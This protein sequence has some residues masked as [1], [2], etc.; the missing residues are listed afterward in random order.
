MDSSAAPRWGNH[1]ISSDGPIVEECIRTAGQERRVT[2]YD[3]GGEVSRREAGSIP[4]RRAER[5]F[6]RG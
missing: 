5:G 2:W 6:T 3:R 4:S 1:D